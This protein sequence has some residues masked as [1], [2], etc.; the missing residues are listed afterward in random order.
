MNRRFKEC[1]H[2]ERQVSPL[3]LLR[4]WGNEMSY[5][6]SFGQLQIDPLFLNPLSVELVLLPV[7]DPWG[8]CAEEEGGVACVRWHSTR[9]T[10]GAMKILR[11]V[12]LVRGRCEFEED[13]ATL[14]RRLSR[15][16]RE[17]ACVKGR[18]HVFWP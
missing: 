10:G 12:M 18:L 5:Q 3:A 11:G 14:S 1:Q 2:L 6:C 13:L 15:R 16:R 9:R 7:A 17:G 8:A 4:E